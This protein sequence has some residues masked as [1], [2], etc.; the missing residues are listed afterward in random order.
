[1]VQVIK[2]V[3]NDSETESLTD[4]NL[5][6]CRCYQL[7]I[8]LWSGSQ[9]RITARITKHTKARL[10]I[11]INTLWDRKFTYFRSSVDY[12][13]YQ[14]VDIP[15]RRRRQSQDWQC[16][17]PRG[18]RR[19]RSGRGYRRAS[20]LKENYQQGINQ[21]ER[22]KGIFGH[23]NDFPFLYWAASYLVYYSFSCAKYTSTWNI[24]YINIKNIKTIPQ[25]F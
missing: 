11:T 24:L 1:M 14:N 22:S 16:W 19:H 13:W 12:E 23:F 6:S 10:N 4:G 18:L 15:G 20:S 21:T 3:R 2:C 9:S 7:A 17:R 5:S 25:K 8:V